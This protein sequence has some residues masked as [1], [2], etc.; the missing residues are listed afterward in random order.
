MSFFDWLNKEWYLKLFDISLFLL[1]FGIIARV[2]LAFFKS[3][4]KV[5][6]P[7]TLGELEIQ[8]GTN[9]TVKISDFLA[10]KDE[11]INSLQKQVAELQ[12]EIEERDKKIEELSKKIELLS[13]VI[14]SLEEEQQK[15][16]LYKEFLKQRTIPLTQ[17][18]VFFNL[19]QAMYE[20]INFFDYDEKNPVEAV[21]VAIATAFL[22]KCK[23]K[24]FYERL[25]D[26]VSN[27]SASTSNKEAFEQLHT[28]LDNIMLWVDAYNREAKS[29]T[30]QL[31]NGRTLKG[32]P[33]IFINEFNKWHDGHVSI[34]LRKIRDVLY[35]NFYHSWQLKTILILDFIDIAFMQTILDAQQTLLS[36]NGE[37]EKFCTSYID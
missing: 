4:G 5:K 12:Q 37:F 30:I 25:F 13:Q 9:E 11:Q 27:L 35:N 2:L 29:L 19:K 33:Q 26:F 20:K 32:V 28:V 16:K 6:L 14:S 17:H 7:K 18:S 10:L 22:T 36:L 24:I 31:P 23:M 21:K 3:G 8:S 34:L 15:D 1:V